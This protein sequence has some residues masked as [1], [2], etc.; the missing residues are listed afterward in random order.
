MSL[1]GHTLCTRC[2]CRL[3]A[4]HACNVLALTH[5]LL[6]LHWCADPALIHQ[7]QHGDDGV[8]TGIIAAPAT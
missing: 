4:V 8:L 7:A 5:F 3:R 1:C 6:V 2:L